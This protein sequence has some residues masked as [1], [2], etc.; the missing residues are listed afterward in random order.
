MRS[1]ALAIMGVLASGC[2]RLRFDAHD[3]AAGAI[4][5][6]IGDAPGTCARWSTFA[7]PQVLPG[8]IQSASDDWFPTP[9]ADQL[10]LWFYSVRGGD[11]DIYVATRASIADPFS[12]AVQVAEL[13]T[14]AS[15]AGPT[16]TAD[17][18]H[19]VFSRDGLPERALFETVR[20]TTNDPWGTPIGI[21][22]IHVA[23]QN[24]YDPFLT[25]DGLR[26]MFVSNRTG[27]Y[28]L[29]EATRPT[30]DAAFGAATSIDE[31]GL[32]QSPTLS[33]D[34]LDIMF[35][36]TRAPTVG[37]HDIWR[38]SR[39]A[40]DQPFAAP[41]H[42]DELATVMDEFGL[43]LSYDGATLYLNYATNVAGGDNSSLDVTTRVCP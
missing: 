13:D 5:D 14:A 39:P 7:V 33:T 23:G 27:N 31:L 16:V 17:E 8:P 11:D 12:A 24:D 41:T 21:V 37:A 43:R 32:A 18:L 9:S 36:S 19:M 40:L 25:A 1:I 22:A 15:E 2:G 35:A 38:A 29:F 28:A 4:T 20:L 10:T 30:I 26:L 34:G 6:A 42:V 3:A